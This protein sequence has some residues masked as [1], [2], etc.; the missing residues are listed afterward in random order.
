MPFCYVTRADRIRVAAITGSQEPVYGEEA[1]HSICKT[2][3]PE[4]AYSELDASDYAW[5]APEWGS[6]V[7]TQTFYI[8]ADS[9]HICFAQIIHS[10]PTCVYYCE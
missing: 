10:N 2:V 8:A 6:N 1:I 5:I 3:T 4:T 7:E 9:G